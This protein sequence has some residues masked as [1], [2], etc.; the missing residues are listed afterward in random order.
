MKTDV[1]RWIKESRTKLKTTPL[2]AADLDQLETL[3]KEPRQL[4]LYLTATSTNMRSGVVSWAL[5]D[6]T[7]AHEPTLLSDES[8][9]N[10][11]LDAVADG[12]RV[13]QF[14][15]I[16]LYEYK[17]LENDYVGFEFILEKWR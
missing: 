2:D 16:N 14:P 10:N 3:M 8:P 12:W 13:A 15:V 11:V 9:Y 17:D 6:S 1:K 5:Y 4:I 7:K